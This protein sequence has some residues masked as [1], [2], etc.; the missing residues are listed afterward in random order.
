M[1]DRLM[2]IMELAYM[3]N[4]TKTKREITGDKPTI[5]IDFAG[6]ISSV[7][8]HIHSNGWSWGSYADEDYYINFDESKNKSYICEADKCIEKLEDILELVESE[9]RHV[10]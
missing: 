8:I 3:I 2:R 5:F 1:K 9:E 7:H 6:H 10:S 4:P